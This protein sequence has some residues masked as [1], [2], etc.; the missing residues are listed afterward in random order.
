MPVAREVLGQC[1]ERLDALLFEGEEERREFDDLLVLRRHLRG[2][3][4]GR[5]EEVRRA[6]GEAVREGKENV[7]GRKKGN[8]GR[9]MKSGVSAGKKPSETVKGKAESD[10]LVCRLAL[11]TVTNDYAKVVQAMREAEERVERRL[12]EIHFK[13]KGRTGDTPEKSDADRR[14]SRPR[15]GERDGGREQE[16]RQLQPEAARTEPP[17]R[18]TPPPEPH[19]F[20]KYLRAKSRAEGGE[21]NNEEKEFRRGH[22]HD[23]VSLDQKD[24]ERVAQ[25]GDND[26]R[27]D[28][29][30]KYTPTNR[31]LWDIEGDNGGGVE[32]AKNSVATSPKRGRSPSLPMGIL[33]KILSPKRVGAGLDDVEISDL[34]LE[35]NSKNGEPISPIQGQPQNDLHFE[36]SGEASFEHQGAP[37]V[38][39]PPA[40]LTPPPASQ[41]PPSPPSMSQA[42]NAG[43]TPTKK[44][45]FSPGPTKTKPPLSPFPLRTPPPSKNK[46]KNRTSTKSGSRGGVKET[47]GSKKKGQ[48]IPR[49]SSSRLVS[50]QRRVS[51]RPIDPPKPPQETKFMEK[52]R[53]DLA[54]TTTAKAKFITP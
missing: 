28:K 45:L 13:R 43:T 29:G 11:E 46:T 54:S 18:A 20:E 9:N 52:A 8:D 21:E 39:P 40:F 6:E 22:V 12:E 51:T 35:G 37:L 47:S 48:V 53:R 36:T 16:P 38:P 19:Q 2:C 1:V 50:P 17:P 34:G 33:D 15:Q 4:K 25:G 49:S 42:A 3:V 31:R 27:D 24:I 30:E 26:E 7:R 41:Q 5:E 14:P 44:S 32:E 23:D 10:L